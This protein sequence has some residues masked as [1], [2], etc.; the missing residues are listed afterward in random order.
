M[1]ETP[2]PSTTKTRVQARAN[3]AARSVVRG[4]SGGNGAGSGTI[5]PDDG[6]GNPPAITIEWGPI[7][8]DDEPCS[9]SEE[10]D[11]G[12]QIIQFPFRIKCN[13]NQP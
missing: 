4:L 8:P 11:G 12:P 7:P 3:A 1:T 9:R 13:L 5:G 2:T 10:G 6:S